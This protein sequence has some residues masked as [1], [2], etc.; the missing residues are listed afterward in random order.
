MLTAG[1][2][3]NRDQLRTLIEQRTKEYE[4]AHGPIQVQAIIQKGI[5]GSVWKKPAAPV[6]DK[7]KKLS[8]INQQI[9]DGYPHTDCAKTFAAQLGITIQALYGRAKR[10]GV[11]RGQYKHPNSIRYAQRIDEV[12]KLVRS[13]YTLKE[14]I[15]KTGYAEST[16]RGYYNEVLASDRSKRAGSQSHVDGPPALR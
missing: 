14:V 3:T 8:S 1:T 12:R 15:A 16:A 10:L 4:S 6:V 7:P 9:I 2:P 5:D 13:G 11:E